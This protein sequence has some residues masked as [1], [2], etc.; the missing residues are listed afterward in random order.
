MDA[1]RVAFVADTH[2]QFVMTQNLVDR[3]R[4]ENVD[5]VVHL[6]DIDDEHTVEHFTVFD[7]FKAIFGN[8]DRPRT[9]IQD[10]VNEIGEHLGNEAMLHLNG[11]QLFIYHGEYPERG[12]NVA[13]YPNGVQYVL[14]GHQ[15][16]TRRESFEN[17]E[18]LNP[19]TA[20]AWVYDSVDDD[21][22]FVTLDEEMMYYEGRSEARDLSDEG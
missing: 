2:G 20:S 4:E 16:E 11:Q 13:E 17:G 7:T 21:W 9:A 1:E 14:H 19:G 5:S 18:V 22:E 15:H 8:H 12:D 6:G 3:I 10:A